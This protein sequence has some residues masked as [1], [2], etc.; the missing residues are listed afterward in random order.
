[1]LPGGSRSPTRAPSHRKSPGEALATCVIDKLTSRGGFER[2]IASL[3][4]ML[5]GSVSATLAEMGDGIISLG[6]HETCEGPDG[7]RYDPNNWCQN[8]NMTSGKCGD[9]NCDT[10]EGARRRAW[11]R[12]C[13]TGVRGRTIPLPTSGDRR[14][15]PNAPTHRSPRAFVRRRTNGAEWTISPSKVSAVPPLR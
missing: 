15:R 12:R 8:F 5:G 1:M 9:N 11:P 3:K 10:V 4:V 7:W 2:Q 13:A 14:R 6:A